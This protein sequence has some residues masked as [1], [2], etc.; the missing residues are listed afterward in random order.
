MNEFPHLMVPDNKV[1][2]TIVAGK[3]QYSKV[4]SPRAYKGEKFE[5]ELVCL[6]GRREDFNARRW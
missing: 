4:K 3:S 2:I 5:G 1:I 6:G